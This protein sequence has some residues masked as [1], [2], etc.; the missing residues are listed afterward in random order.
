MLNFKESYY[1]QEAISLKSAKKRNLSRKNSGAYNARLNE[2]FDNKDRL[3]FDIE[4][5]DKSLITPKNPL[6]DKILDFLKTKYPELT[7]PTKQDYID[8]LAYNVKDKDKKQPMRIG[9]LLNKHVSEESVNLLLKA[10][11]ED[12]IRGAKKVSDYKVVISRHPYD[13]AGVSTDRAWTSCMNL[14]TKGIF[15]GDK[16]SGSNARFVVKDI[17]FG[18]I[19]AYLISNDDRHA[20]GKIAINRPISRILMKPHIN[21][22]DKKDIA[23]SLGRTYNVPNQTFRQFVSNWLEKKVNT[24]TAGKGYYL[25]PSLYSDGDEPVNFNKVR[26]NPKNKAVQV[27]YDLLGNETDPKHFNKLEIEATNLSEIDIPDVYPEVEVKFIFDIPKKNKLKSVFYGTG[28]FPK[29][30]TEM[31]DLLGITI[32]KRTTLSVFQTFVETNTLVIELSFYSRNSGF[33]YLD[34]KGDY[35]HMDDDDIYE[36]WEIFL[37]DYGFGD[38]NYSEV[39]KEIVGYLEEGHGNLHDSEYQ[40]EL[41]DALDL[42]ERMKKHER[43]A[44]NVEY[45]KNEFENLKKV[46]ARIKQIHDSDV[47]NFQVNNQ[48]IEDI[49]FIDD[50]KKRYNAILVNFETILRARGH[51]L[52]PKTIYREWV[53]NYVNYDDVIS[54][55]KIA[56]RPIASGMAKLNELKNSL[57]T[58][59]YQN[60]KDFLN[61]TFNIDNINSTSYVEQLYKK[62]N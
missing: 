40:I 19:V 48:L 26:F 29:Y 15:Y 59:R 3:V 50:Y 41:D 46:C 53:N 16:D 54:T 11:K 42:F 37:K 32:D 8:G 61:M 56:Q 14:G 23:Y 27:F 43:I 10:F 22:E 17:E 4:L 49:E 55:L 20:N 12:P 36:Y 9:K 2:I 5:S 35:I 62:T 47:D 13:I 31:V 38:F 33:G 58:E 52:L 6:I 21:R 18:S 30:A 60:Y 51:K 34:D 7:I 1:L 39:S 25:H 28:D 44:P 57:D 24:N 45:M